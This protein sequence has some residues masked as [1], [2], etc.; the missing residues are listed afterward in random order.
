MQSETKQTLPSSRLMLG[1]LFGIVAIDFMHRQLMALLMQ[2][3]GEELRL[4]DTQLGSII[5]I[6]ALCYGV[7]SP[8]IAYFADRSH[9]VNLLTVSLLVWSAVSALSGFAVGFWSL[10]LS[11]L[12]V[13]VLSSGAMPIGNSLLADYIPANKRAAANRSL[14][15]EVSELLRRKSQFR[16]AQPC[17]YG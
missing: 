17:A 16:R 11:R 9:R 5:T 8:L 1:A 7:G 13:G 3:M 10:L 12:G 14:T 6:Y 4:S 2:P 15:L